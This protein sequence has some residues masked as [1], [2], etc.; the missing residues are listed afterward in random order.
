MKIN[1]ILLEFGFVPTS[2]Y[3]KSAVELARKMEGYY[4]DGEGKDIK[5]YVPIDEARA[6]E[7]LELYDIA[8]KWKNT[9]LK[10]GDQIAAPDYQTLYVLSC[11]IIRCEVDNKEQY[12]HD[13]NWIG[14]QR[15]F[16]GK[17]LGLYDGKFDGTKTYLPDKESIQDSVQRHSSNMYS[18]CPVFDI[19]QAIQ[20]I[21]RLPSAI[22]LSEN[23]KW[24]PIVDTDYHSGLTRLSGIQYTTDEV[25]KKGPI[26]ESIDDFDEYVF[27]N[28]NQVNKPRSIF[29][30][31]IVTI[32]HEDWIVQTKDGEIPIINEFGKSGWMLVSTLLDNKLIYCV[33]QREY[34]LK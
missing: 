19:E 11:F 9:R 24:I 33:F 20:E 1:H 23:P 6:K 10:Y 5:H 21:N 22:N 17:K 31:K 32:N 2:N 27:E 14:C 25:I 15:V 34:I 7:W 8:K 26:V 4:S 16:R 3:Y 30:H 29:E 28:A 12:C 13:G 18:I